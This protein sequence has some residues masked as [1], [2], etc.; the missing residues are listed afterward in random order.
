MYKIKLRARNYTP[1]PFILEKMELH[2]T[3][4]KAYVRYDELVKFIQELFPKD[5]ITETITI[6]LE[7][8]DENNVLRAVLNHD[9]NN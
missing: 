9:I 6:L 3:F 8:R 7:L 1:L 4:A 5:E 2:P